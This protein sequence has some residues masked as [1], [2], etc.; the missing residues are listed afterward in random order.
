MVDRP[1]S[2][3]LRSPT[4]HDRCVPS[5]RVRPYQ[6]DVSSSQTRQAACAG[7]S[8]PCQHSS[9]PS[10]PRA[11]RAGARC[12]RCHTHLNPSQ[13]HALPEVVE[14]PP[15]LGR[16]TNVKHHRH[17]ANLQAIERVSECRSSF[18]ISERGNQIKGTDNI[19]KSERSLS[20]WLGK[21]IELGIRST[22]YPG[23]CFFPHPLNAEGRAGFGG[24]YSK[25]HHIS[26][27]RPPR[28]AASTPTEP[29]RWT[30]GAPAVPVDGTAQSLQIPSADGA[31]A[32]H[33]RLGVTGRST[34][35]KS[36]HTARWTGAVRAP[37]VESTST[38]S[39][40]KEVA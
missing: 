22:S 17:R 2:A 29:S 14:S 33:G 3:H 12:P 40:K 31:R 18:K 21:F 5:S 9:A 7:N 20:H 1:Q 8:D 19:P 38:S 6:A 30:S 35:P 32:R 23:T 15:K 11:S 16:V 36:Q 37:R 13:C 24:D 4:S 27:V 28:R 10:L 39:T 26:H 34:G 25:H